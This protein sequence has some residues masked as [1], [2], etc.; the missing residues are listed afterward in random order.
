[1]FACTMFAA[2]IMSGVQV[3]EMHGAGTTNPSKL[4]WQAM[5]IIGER[6]RLPLHLTYRAVGSSTGQK[7]FVGNDGVF[8]ALNHFGSGDIPMT[9]SRYAQVQA[10]GRQMVHV[11]F[12]MGAIGVFH[13]VPA[14]GLG[15]AP[16]DLT[17]CLLAKIFSRKIT[18]WG[19]ADIKA[20]NP[21]MTYTGPIKVVHRV[22]GSS[23]TAGFTEYING[24]CSESWAPLTTG[25]TI[26]WPQDT[27]SAQGSGG[28]AAY[29]ADPENEGAIGYIDA[30]HG[31]SAGLSEIE[32]MNK[33][34]LYLSTREADIGAAG[35]VALTSAIPVIPSDP[36]SDFSSVNLY[37]LEGPTT[38][39]ITMISYFYLEKDMSSYD[40]VT[41]AL[42][43]YFVRFILSEEGQ[44]MAQDNMFVKLPQQIL[45]YNTVTLASITTPSTM[46][47]FITE[48]ASTTQARV[49]AGQYV[50]SGKR[51]SFA[52]VERSNNKVAI[53]ANTAGLASSSPSPT[54]VGTASSGFDPDTAGALGIAG[55]ILG[56]LGFVLGLVAIMMAGAKNREMKPRSVEIKARD[57]EV[58][59][60]T[61]MKT[62]RT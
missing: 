24:K 15:G 38:W 59:S 21:S 37:D 28:M 62:E 47:A 8:T 50:I 40:P 17:G 52:E 45:D 18:D 13:S 2:S 48:L 46:P 7:E 41:A 58:P 30:G 43:M 49:G 27:A 53:A 56:T 12:A 6:S 26:A 16:L 25:S 39:P 5:D 29:I 4:F 42:V 14:S 19:H 20:V 11:P 55:L 22:E 9:S 23:S 34:G 3:E 10:A 51:R 60:S 31:Y 44:S 32:L 33:D 1:M 35:T 36:T 57:I 54:S 61:T